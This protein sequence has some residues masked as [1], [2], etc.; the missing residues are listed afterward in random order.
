MNFGTLL[1]PQ[2]SR[3]MLLVLDAANTMADAAGKVILPLFRQPLEVTN[4]K[5]I[6]SELDPVTEADRGA[7]LIIRSVIDELFPDDGIL[8]EEFGLKKGVSGYQWILDPIDGTGAFISGVPQW[9][10][11]IALHDGQRAVFGLILGERYFGYKGRAEFVTQ[12]QVNGNLAVRSCDDI[13][14]AVLMTT[15]P[16]LFVGDKH[17]AFQQVRQ[18]VAMTRYGG[19]CY[20]YCLLAAGHSDLIIETNLNPYDIQAL[21]PIIEAAGGIVSDWSGGPV[22]QGG[23]VIVAGD[24]RV[25][26]QA[27]SLINSVMAELAG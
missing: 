7:E 19:D 24:K 11:L 9:G 2:S 20:S 1:M 12:A 22:P 25:H 17:V 26:A 8:G 10:T 15:S 13:A 5:T 27:L 21:I 23:D 4:K 14:N 16:D 6:G 3:D 18:T